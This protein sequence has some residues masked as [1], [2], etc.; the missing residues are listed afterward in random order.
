MSSRMLIEIICDEC[1]K[2][3]TYVH[4]E[5]NQLGTVAKVSPFK[6]AK[7]NGWSTQPFEDSKLLI[8]N[9]CPTCTIRRSNK[10][11]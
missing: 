1:S 8:Q 4:L 9:Y 5:C 2:V 10:Q 3:E 7:I 11:S 6:A